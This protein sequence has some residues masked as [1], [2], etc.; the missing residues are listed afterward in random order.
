[1]EDKCSRMKGYLGMIWMYINSV[2]DWLTVGKK[3]AKDKN[4]NNN[5]NLTRNNFYKWK[6]M[7]VRPNLDDCLMRLA[8][9]SSMRE[10]R[11]NFSTYSL[12]PNFFSFW[13]RRMIFSVK[14][15]K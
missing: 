12:I 9:Y 8:P 11:E 15:E 10:K 13:S 7:P 4:N 14:R 2:R 6:R 5:N 3:N 1:M